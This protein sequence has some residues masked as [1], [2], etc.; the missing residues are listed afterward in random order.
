MCPVQCVTYV[1]GRSGLSA[2][3]ILR[4]ANQ[5]LY[6][7]LIGSPARPNRAEN[8]ARS[9]LSMERRSV[10]QETGFESRRFRQFPSLST[11][12]SM[13]VFHPRVSQIFQ[14]GVCKLNLDDAHPL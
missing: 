10:T 4:D 5:H 9:S 7:L 12:L 2:C 1:S 3:T 14:S 8:V 11:V 6:L 13:H